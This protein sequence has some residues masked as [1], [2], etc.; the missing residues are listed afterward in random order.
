MI[1]NSR[2]YTALIVDDE[3]EIIAALYRHFRKKYNCLKANGGEQALELIDSNAIDLLLCDQRMPNISGDQV[4]AHMH[5]TQPDSI[6][7]LMTGYADFESLVKSVN[8]GQIYR[9]VAKPWDT[10]EL[11]LTIDR[12]LESLQLGRDLI[13]ARKQIEDAYHTAVKMLCVASEGK[14]EDTASH[15]QRVRYY[16]K[17]LALCYGIPEIDAEHLGVMSILHDI[18]KMYIPDSILKKPGPL[19]DSEWD[20]MKKHPRYGKKILGED[21]F[22]ELAATI[23]LGHHENWDG[24]GYPKCLIGEQI[25]L[26]ARIVKLTDV[27]DALTTRRPYKDAWS[28]SKAMEF[29]ND[30]KA[31]MFDPTLVDHLNN[32]YDDSTLAK[33]HTEYVDS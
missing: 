15:I 26:A 6:R 2:K 27:F 28:L 5:Q 12:A 10:N 31:I 32:L 3:P 23:A 33:I 8:D 17:A 16:S 7:I 19:D 4:L 1:N 25:P 29:I 13:D 9:Y 18:G 20:V 22:Y 21:P 30:K 24:S 11:K 14:D